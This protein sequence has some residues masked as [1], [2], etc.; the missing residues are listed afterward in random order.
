MRLAALLSSAAL[1]AAVLAPASSASAVAVT[2]VQTTVKISCAFTT[3][4]QPAD[5][6]LPA[7]TPKGLVWLQHGFARSKNAVADLAGKY[8]AQGYVAFAP[9]L[10]IANLFGCTLQNLG[11]NTDFMANIGKLFGQ[12]ASSGGQLATSFAKAKAAA[13]RPE[14]TLPTKLVF[15]GHSAGGEAVTYVANRV[16]TD[17]PA[18][19]AN[20]RGLV[21]LDPVN[22]VIGSNLKTGLQGLNTT[23]KPILT[24]SGA[25]GTCNSSGSGTDLVQA[26]LDRPFVGARLTTGSHVDAEGASTDAIGTLACGTS[27]PANVAI[28]QSLAVTWLTDQFEGTTTA[29]YY[30]GGSYYDSKI[31]SGELQTL[32]G[33]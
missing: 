32:A 23:T 21:L 22:A 5:W 30:P 10:P 17:Y 6:Y 27:N 8:A 19:F 9:S 13:N 28:L 26:E 25:D 20:L 12:A 31:A 7:G 24:V 29:A 11:N 2:R 4:D 16:R 3:L 15:S 33:S 18:T 14:L 1:A